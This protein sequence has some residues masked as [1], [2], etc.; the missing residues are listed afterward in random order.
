[1]N[2]ISFYLKDKKNPTSIRMRIYIRGKAHHYPTFVS[3]NPT[4]WCTEKGVLFQRSLTG[5]M[6]PWGYNINMKLNRIE[7]AAER[8]RSKMDEGF[9]YAEFKEALDIELQ[10]KKK[11]I[12]DFWAYVHGFIDNVVKT[13]PELKAGRNS[14]LNSYNQTIDLLHAFESK[15]GR[16]EFERFDADFYKR[17][18]NYCHSVKGFKPNTTGRHVKT[19]KTWLNAATAEG[20]NTSLKYK[21]FKVLRERTAEIYLLPQEIRQIAESALHPITR[22]IFIFA[23]WTGLRYVDYVQVTA[24]NIRDGSLMFYQSKTG[25]PVVIPL[26]PECMEIL[27]RYGGQLPKVPHNQVMNRYLKEIAHAIGMPSTRASKLKT[28]TARRSFATNLFLSGFP[29]HDIMRITGHKTEKSF[30]LYIRHDNQDSADR[31]RKHWGL[32]E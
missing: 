5:K 19:L 14:I 16:L 3:I 18:L 7:S 24:A 17:F 20:V 26:R 15:F 21:G 29:A 10:R 13:R 1:M 11:S 27:S 12:Q 30:L 31:L 22:D 28:H 9:T 25:N 32:S 2:G 23:C 8:V 6:F 4:H